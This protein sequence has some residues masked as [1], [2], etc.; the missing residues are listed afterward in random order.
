MDN[1]PM[2]QMPPFAATRF[3]TDLKAGIDQVKTAT[4]SPGRSSWILRTRRAAVS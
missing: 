2:D 1:F 4:K 3:M